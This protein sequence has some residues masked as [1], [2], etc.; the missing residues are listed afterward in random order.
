MGVPALAAF[1]LVQARLARAPLM[2]LRIFRARSVSGA[3][4]AGLAF[5]P[6]TLAIVVV[7]AKATPRL[8]S[9]FGLRPLPATGALISGYA[10]AFWVC[11][12]LVTAGA[13]A[14]LALPSTVKEPQPGPGHH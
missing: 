7:A 12:G 6:H 5:L 10:L 1:V 2:P 14:V 8:V 13:V 9:R 11:A 4:Q 3:R